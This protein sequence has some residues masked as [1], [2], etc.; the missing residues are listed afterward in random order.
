MQPRR[1]LVTGA[2]GFVAGHL[3]GALQAAFPQAALTLCQPGGADIDITDAAA[4]DALIAEIRPDVCVHLAAGTADTAAQQSPDHAW[5]VN[6]QGSLSLGRAMLAHA[7]AGLMLFV[8][9]AE[10]YGRSF[11]AGVALDET[12]AAAPMNTYAATKAAADLALGAM[13]SDGLRVVR[14]RPFNHT[15]PGQTASFAVPAFA[16]QIAR[17]AVGLQP[18]TMTVGTLDS[19][20]DFLDVRDVCRAYVACIHHAER[21]EP[22]VILNIASGVRR[23]IG[24]VLAELLEIGGVRAEV[25]TAPGLLRPSEIPVAYGDAGRAGALVAWHPEIAWRQTLLDVLADWKGRV[26]TDP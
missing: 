16:R 9:S 1:I 17:I 7:P 3:V 22:G 11:R 18:P 6:L 23:R 14:L 24:D 26:A 8:S 12:A 4:V 10:I 20:R 19:E 2:A 25:T 13:A 21:L 5:Q 15:G